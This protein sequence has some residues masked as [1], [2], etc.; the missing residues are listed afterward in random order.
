MKPKWMAGALLLA[1]CFLLSACGNTDRVERVYDDSELYSKE[2]IDAAMDTVI[3]YFKTDM[4]GCTL[5]EVEF[6][7]RG[8][9]AEDNQEWAEQYDADQAILIDTVFDVENYDG[10]E[11]AFLK[12]GKTY[13]NFIWI[14]TRNDNGAWEMQ[15]EGAP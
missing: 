7:E 2:D 8:N 13:D 6:D 1:G 10:E 3:A 12:S 14:L 4:Q 15:T 5:T 9:L 11:Y